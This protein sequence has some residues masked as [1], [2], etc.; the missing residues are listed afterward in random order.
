[1]T[2]TFEGEET[3]RAFDEARGEPGKPLAR[4][5]KLGRYIVIEELGRGGMANVV[6]AYDS[7]LRRNVALKMLRRDLV[8]AQGE[9]RLVRE[10]QAMAR[11]SDPAVVTVFDV[12]A[13]PEGVVI[14]M[15]LVE[16]G[17]LTRW[18]ATDRSSRRILEVFAQAGR[19]LATAH[20]AGIIHRDFKP[21][22]VLMTEDERPKVADFGIARASA[23]ADIPDADSSAHVD[24]GITRA[25][26]LLGT[27][28]Y[29][30]PEQRHKSDVDARADQYAFCVA[31]WEALAGY[32]PFAG[33]G[34]PE[35]WAAKAEGAPPLPASAKVS[36]RIAAAI[37][38]GLAPAPSERWPDMDA[39][40]DAL[41]DRETEVRRRRVGLA[42]AGAVVIIGG[43]VAWTTRGA[44]P[45]GD[46]GT[47]LAGIWD[48]TRARELAAALQATGATY[49]GTMASRLRTDLDA[50]TSDWSARHREV[51]EATR[52]RHERPIA[53]MDLRMA[54]LFRAK[55]ELGG[56]ID[57]L[58]ELDRSA[59]AGAGDLVAGLPEL[60]QCDDATRLASQ[61]PRAIDPQTAAAID[62][63]RARLAHARA[64]GESGRHEDALAEAQTVAETAEGLD[65]PMLAADVALV[66]ARIHGLAGDHDLAEAQFTSA[67]TAA[68]ALDDTDRSIAATSGFA[69][70]LNEV[71]ARP[72]RALG[73]SLVAVALAE[74]SDVD[75]RSRADALSTYGGVLR[76]LGRYAESET[77]PR[78]ALEIRI[79]TLGP[80]HSH[81]ATSST[82]L[83]LVLVD[84]GRLD[85]AIAEHRR[86]VQ[87]WRDAYGDGHPYVAL[88]RGNLGN[89]LESSGRAI[90]AVAELQ[91]AVDIRLQ[92]MSPEDP[93]LGIAHND[94]G[95]ALASAGRHAEA[96]H[97]ARDAIR[98]WNEAL[99]PNDRRI[100]YGRNNLG[101]ALEGQGRLVEAEVEF[102]RS[103]TDVER[104]MGKDHPVLAKLWSNV[105]RVAHARGHD[106]EAESLYRRALELRERA[107]SPEHSAVARTLAAMSDVLVAR[108]RIDE[109]LEATARAS[110]IV[111]AGPATA[112]VQLDVA[113]ARARALW[114]AEHR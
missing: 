68:L 88:A 74:R 79:A 14:A 34:T 57:V 51:C 108:G 85:E 29:M 10:A 104:A 17:T 43:L 39:L 12:A 58:L 23:I 37:A 110:T 46:A 98:I 40:L 94:L 64:V 20:R 69:F 41:A 3:A 21:S 95:I 76:A 54:C 55:A 15:E 77:A 113:A 86:A 112:D 60:A 84:L 78:R 67:M 35:L 5:T 53:E 28:R 32:S 56:V 9:V 96:E 2:D 24:L 106:E 65:D 80:V 81:V 1:M 25:G 11:L 72:E 63:L 87:I 6:R 38:R 4:G 97:E 16:G 75:E 50:Y 111:A 83:G 82:N 45:C 61:A 22:N 26:M 101:I 109:A 114:A 47:H 105:A 42:A 44:A 91:A 89:A 99:G 103:A 52:I 18:L 66:L 59:L 73:L 49:A 90:E 19:G 13:M 33:D 7:K 31:L 107:L 62:G 48:E 70:Y 100:G 71:Q 102:R 92:T 93:S 36:P 27:P 8:G 30:A